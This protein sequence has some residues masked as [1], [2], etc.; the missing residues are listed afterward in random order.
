MKMERIDSIE[1]IFKSLDKLPTL[2][3]IAMRILAAVRNQA[4]SLKE[5]GD[6]LATDP[7]LSAEVLRAINSPFYGLP[8]KITSVSHAVNLLGIKTVKSLALSFSLV[9]NV[10]SKESNGFDYGGFWKNSLVGAVSAKILAE[11]VLPNFSEDAFFLGLIHNIGILAMNQSIPEQYRLVL[12]EKERNLCS[13]QEAEN[14]VLGFN[15]MQLGEYLAQSWGL[16]EMFS[17]PIRQHHEFED[18]TGENPQIDLIAKLLKLAALFIVLTNVR[19]KSFYVAMAQLEILIKRWGFRKQLRIDEII[20]QIHSQ[21]M[22]VFPLFDIEIEQDTDYFRLIEEARNALIHLSSDFM[23]QLF[24]QK[25]LIQSLSEQTMRDALTNLLNFHAFHESL[26]KEIQRAKRYGHHLG[27]IMADIDHFKDINDNYGHLAGDYILK[28]VAK[29]LKN[30]LRTSDVVARYG[31]EEFAIILPETSAKDT[32]FVAE[33]LR[34]T[35]ASKTIEYENQNLSV[36]LSFG[37]SYIEPARMRDKTDLIK[38]ADVALYQAKRE[39]R[40]TCR[41]FEGNLN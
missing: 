15:H 38:E 2:P 7:S 18:G 31:G 25:K 9:K 22:N 41:C 10:R 14:Q 27:L 26:Q 6:I 35:I 5:I 17:A 36:S 39:G 34:E 24:E 11:K 16:P 23:Q 19:D 21:T 40:N 4:T 3:G 20:Q 1:N 37:I 28:E 30:F 33:R 29:F 13:Y 12:K 32:I 8:V